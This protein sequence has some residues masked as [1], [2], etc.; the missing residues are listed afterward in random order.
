MPKEANRGKK[1]GNNNQTERLGGPAAKAAAASELAAKDKPANKPK[2]GAVAHGK[3]KGKLIG[4][5]E[6]GAVQRVDLVTRTGKRIAVTLGPHRRFNRKVDEEIAQVEVRGPNEE[7]LASQSA[8][9]LSQEKDGSRN[10]DLAKDDPVLQKRQQAADRRRRMRDQAGKI[11]ERLVR[12]VD[13]VDDNYVPSR[14]TPDEVAE[15]VRETIK[16]AVKPG[17]ELATTLLLKDD[18]WAQLEKLVGEKDGKRFQKIS[19]SLTLL[20]EKAA[21][22]SSESSSSK[23]VEALLEPTS[24]LVPEKANEDEKI[25]NAS[26]AADTRGLVEKTIE[27]LL[28]NGD[29][30]DEDFSTKLKNALSAHLTL[31]LLAEVD[32]PSDYLSRPFSS[33]DLGARQPTVNLPT[34]PSDSPA[35]HDF[36]AVRIALPKLWSSLFEKETLKA[37]EKRFTDAWD[38]YK[39]DRAWHIPDEI[40]ADAQLEDLLAIADEIGIESMV[41]EKLQSL[42][43][44]VSEREYLSFSAEDRT[45]INLALQEFAVLEEGQTTA[46]MELL[47][48]V[49]V[50]YYGNTYS[51]TFYHVPGSPATTPLFKNPQDAAVYVQLDEEIAGLQVTTGQTGASPDRKTKDGKVFYIGLY[52]PAE[53]T[54]RKIRSDLYLV[55]LSTYK[56]IRKQ[57]IGRVVSVARDHATAD[58]DTEA[59]A[60]SSIEVLAQFLARNNPEEKILKKKGLFAS[61]IR[62]PFDHFTPRSVNFG[63]MLNYKQIWIPLAYQAGDL[64]ATIPL[65]P[66]EI[67]KFSKKTVVKK[68]RKQK[69]L[70]SSLK[71]I[72]DESQD[73]G[74]TESEIVKKAHKDTKFASHAQAS[75][76]VGAFSFSGSADQE[77]NAANDLDATRKNMREATSKASQKFKQERKLEI[78]TTESTTMEETSSGEISNPN[79]EIAVTYLFYELQRRYYVTEFLA[80]IQ[81]IALVAAPVPTPSEITESFLI[82]HDWILKRALLDD[83]YLEAFEVIKDTQL[84]RE[85]E[86]GVRKQAVERQMEALRETKEQLR[87]S[88]RLRDRALREIDAAVDLLQ[89]TAIGTGAAN[90]AQTILTG[91]LSN[92]FGGGGGDLSE[93]IE[94]AA[95]LQAESAQEALQR[96]DREINRLRTR[97]EMSTSALDQAITSYAEVVRET[98]RR[99][100]AVLRLR[101]HIAQNILHY[102]HAIWEYQ[103]LD[104]RFFELYNIRVPVIAG[105]VQATPGGNNNKFTKVSLKT[106]LEVSDETVPLHQIADL[107]TLLGFKGNYLMFPMKTPNPLTYYMAQP[108]R[109]AVLPPEKVN[110]LLAASGLVSERAEEIIKKTQGAQKGNGADDPPAVDWQMI[111]VPSGLEHIEVL[112]DTHSVL[113]PFKLKH[114]HVD[115][116]DAIAEMKAKEAERIRLMLRLID[117][118]YED[119]DPVRNTLRIESEGTGIP[120]TSSPMPELP[121]E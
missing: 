9:Q 43:Q 28:T 23:S 105:T 60:K 42:G 55:R 121:V 29:L 37:L 89:G 117:G 49:P 67:R 45:A 11:A 4:L 81:D 2:G 101:V 76:S 103:I 94:E 107:D 86:V 18:E 68:D 51:M 38:D 54:Q 32:L 98:L 3:F 46:E 85:T 112:P 118:N 52:L 90:T 12:E 97:L 109:E 20:S 56:M 100:Q 75:G 40:A 82:Q 30:A 16:K 10:I 79:N 84:S 47:P 35:L 116:L 66:G 14:A 69:E 15:K 31:Q 106:T 120:P 39:E 44:I 57:E 24:A 50:N 114:R 13:G 41:V 96:V 93:G 77:N 104:Q 6:G 88:T 62:M 63:I 59:V 5:P 73:T 8:A 22:T 119:P 33:Q 64:I 95:Q 1:T 21:M 71:V 91:G 74:R 108:Y 27:D 61:D 65:A 36:S 72:G 92:L 70:E 26:A 80:G 102:M 83:S 7:L 113:E 99:E 17:H 110:A 53:D 19:Q 48:N 87:T 78:E 115:V 25:S 58:D 34:A 111:T